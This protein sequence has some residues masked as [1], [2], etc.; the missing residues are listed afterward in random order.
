MAGSSSSSSVVRLALGRLLRISPS[1]APRLSPSADV[2]VISSS[3][4]EDVLRGLARAAQRLEER[5]L[6]G[7]KNG[8]VDEDVQSSCEQ[9]LIP[10]RNIAQISGKGGENALIASQGSSMSLARVA[11]ITAAAYTRVPTAGKLSAR[12]HAPSRKQP[13]RLRGAARDLFDA[14]LASDIPRID[15][16][17]GA[18]EDPHIA[19]GARHPQHGGS[20]MHAASICADEKTAVKVLGLLAEFITSEL[21]FELGS[22]ELK[23]AANAEALNGSRPLHWAAG[24]GHADACKFLLGHCGAD[25]FATTYTWSRNTFGKSSGQTACHWAAESGHTHC[26][27][28]F[29]DAD[30]MLCVSHD[31]RGQLPVDL[32]LKEGHDRTADLLSAAAS[33]EYMCIDV[34]LEAAGVLGTETNGNNA[35]GVHNDDKD[36]AI[37]S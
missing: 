35:T 32:A 16:C 3:S 22:M 26:V 25:P 28:L 12:A 30:A 18:I 7:S 24:V 1:P 21:D 37:Q 33:E 5:M 9:I 8:K 13:P 11:S 15:A 2:E 27:E 4:K 23:R 31:E 29:L 19:V 14:V 20:L 6:D 34:S 10:V 36:P 17:L